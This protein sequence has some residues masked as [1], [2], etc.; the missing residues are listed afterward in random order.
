M[1]L[2]ALGAAIIA[3]ALAIYFAAD[4][5]SAWDAYYSVGT[6]RELA[7]R[8][9]L[10]GTSLELLLVV[11]FAGVPALLFFAFD[12]E[13]LQ[14][15]RS[16]FV[17]HVFRF[18]TSVETV[19]DI[20]AKY[21]RM[22]DEA[23]GRETL[24]GRILPGKR[25]PVVIAT[26]AIAL[27]WLLTLP[28]PSY[29]DPGVEDLSVH[30]YLR[31]V[32]E[33]I[34]FAFLGAYFFALNLVF[35]GYVRGDLR[36]KTYSQITVRILLSFVL[37]FVLG[38]AFS[39]NAGILLLAFIGGL[40][41][42]TL[43]VRFREA[44]RRGGDR[45]RSRGEPDPLDA[46]VEEQPLTELEGI[47]IYDRARLEEEGVTNVEALA[48]HDLVELML[49][50]RIPVPR[51]IDWVDQAILYLH[52][53]G[54]TPDA[55]RARETLRLNGIRTGSD[56]LNAWHERDSVGE[57]VHPLADLLETTEGKPSRLELIVEAIEDEEW[58]ELLLNWHRRRGLKAETRTFEPGAGWIRPTAPDSAA[59]S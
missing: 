21:G 2:L 50:T 53:G 37:A 56:L 39:T 1:L 57:G 40:L 16:K 36:P 24:T 12:R 23:Y 10:V 59:A 3:P 34:V 15:L 25:L 6:P 54:R 13:K 38:Q 48:H 49:R 46:L 5:A 41:P 42:E 9:F 28:I 51:L 30:D 58:T 18:D 43:L 20:V 44:A 33:P 7:S 52:L 14:T 22:M 55:R 26:A 8:E 32:E 31:P 11:T 35:R 4:V 19:V 17:A 27:G 45:F 29:L 47:D